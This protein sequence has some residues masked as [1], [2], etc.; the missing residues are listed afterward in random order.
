[1]SNATHESNTTRTMTTGELARA[2][3]LSEKAV[4][5]YTE[6][7]LLSADREQE[8]GWRSYGPDQLV[9]ARTIGLLRGLG[10]SLPD[11]AAVL[12]G[13]DPVTAFDARWSAHRT[14]ADRL[15][16]VGEYVRSVLTGGDPELGVEV[17]VR[18]VPERLTL[19]CEVRASLAELAQVIPATTQRLFGELAAAGNELS[20]PP[21]VVYHERATEQ[22][23]ARLTIGVPVAGLQ[24][25]APGLRLQTEPERLEAFVGLDQE[26]AGT[27]PYVVAVHD[28]LGSDPFEP[29]HR[30]AG[31]NR[32]LYLPT[33]GTGAPGPVMEVG[34]PVTRAAAPSSRPE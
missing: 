10:L 12:D 9:R 6:R 21:F 23:A 26:Q 1:M 2:A 33:W 16:R 25:P 29:H 19:T 17:R 34:V 5:L 30:R 4:R 13:D 11:V 20:G 15:L 31:D 7:A 3:G 27:Q 18:T 14:D 22:F 8:G 32:E 28:Y 24:R